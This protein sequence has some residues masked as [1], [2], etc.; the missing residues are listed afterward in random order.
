MLSTAAILHL[1]H[2][3]PQKLCFTV[4]DFNSYNTV[5][6]G[7]IEGADKKNGRMTLPLGP[8]LGV[9]PNMDVLKQ[10]LYVIN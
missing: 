5:S 9:K 4:T 8:G 6:T 10:P 3:V 1:S 2:T 7:H